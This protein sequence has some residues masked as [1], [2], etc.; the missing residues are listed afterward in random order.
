M[1]RKQRLI[2]GI[3]LALAL[4]CSLIVAVVVGA[5]DISLSAA[6]E[7]INA[8][9]RKST[10]NDV[11]TQIIGQVRFPRA[12]LGA[13]VGAGLG[14][15]GLI[16][17]SLLRNPLGDP[18][19]LGISSGATTGAAAVIVFGTTNSILSSLG[20][21]FGAFLGAIISIALVTL[22]ASAG[23]KITPARII[24][25]G[26]AVTYFF[27]AVTSLIILM[28]KNAA[29]TKS[30]M[31]WM[32]GSI[33]NANWNETIIAGSVVTIALVF[34]TIWG[35]RVDILNLGD[36][37]AISLGTSPRL[38]R[39]LL[40]LIVAFTISVLVSL[41]GAIGFVG[42]V[43]PHVSKQ[44][45]GSTTRA[46]LPI[47]A[48]TGALLVVIADTCARVAIRPAELPIGIL[49]ALVGTPMLMALIKKYS[50]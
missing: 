36:D 12:V 30:V 8:T 49:T 24:F 48:L 43:V 28:A 21:T 20:I 34:F 33:S 5:T 7:G 1:N 46:A 3:L 37:A 44:L 32:L 42:L 38:Y 13:I 23:G 47:S 35:R 22:L 18:Y 29:G 6:L 25:A 19:I 31:F 41:T 26:M 39:N 11:D 16:T 2:L 10:E 45:V 15:C 17:Q 14:I 4:A 9:L 40:F 50:K 27:S